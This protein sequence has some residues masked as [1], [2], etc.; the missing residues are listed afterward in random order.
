MCPAVVTSCFTALVS[1][2]RGEYLEISHE[3]FLPSSFQFIVW[4]LFLRLTLYRQMKCVVSI[5]FKYYKPL[6]SEDFLIHQIKCVQLFP[7]CRKFECVQSAKRTLLMYIAPLTP[8]SPNLSNIPAS[9]TYHSLSQFQFCCCHIKL[10]AV[11]FDWI[12][13]LLPLLSRYSYIVLYNIKT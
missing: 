3:H 1:P 2:S 6:S 8:L 7:G 12:C 10:T 5:A 9:H 4:L 13:Y 11:L